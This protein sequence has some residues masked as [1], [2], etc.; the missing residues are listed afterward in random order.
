[1]RS[2]W[3]LVCILL[4]L[5]LL[6]ILLLA[7]ASHRAAAAKQPHFE[8]LS[9]SMTAGDAKLKTK[10]DVQIPPDLSQSTVLGIL[11]LYTM[12]IALLA[13]KRHVSGI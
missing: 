7:F 4:L 13:R 8:I 1:M 11:P 12:G 10:L 6:L 5:L 2:L 9:H 3:S